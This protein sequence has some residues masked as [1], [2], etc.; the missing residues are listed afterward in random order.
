[1][2][3]RV[4]LQNRVT[5]FSELIA[6]DARGTLMG[7]RGIVHDE[8]RRIRRA[9]AGTRWIICV[10]EFR[11]RHRVVMTPHR[12][13]ELF[14]LD[15]ATALAAGHRPC[16]ECQRP[17]YLAFREAW[18]AGRRDA[19]R[20]VPSAEEAV[21]SAEEMDAV[22]HTERVQPGGAKRTY[23]E[24]VSGLPSGVMVADEQSRAYLVLEGT[25]RPWTPHGYGP[26]QPIDDDALRVLTPPSVVAAIRRG[27]RAE[28]HPSAQTA[29]G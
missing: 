6:T 9:F 19:A 11:N 13:T 5:P 17:R 8:H 24:R 22:L 14:F 20:A 3:L 26:P 27:F 7:N 4:P 29:A 10:L 16:A 25:R 2:I 23:R 12:Y 1:M 15:E 21:P 18:A 28:L